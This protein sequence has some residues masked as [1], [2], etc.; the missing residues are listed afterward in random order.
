MKTKYY[1][2]GTFE[3]EKARLVVQGC[4]AIKGRDYDATRAPTCRM[5][6]VRLIMALMLIFG[7]KAHNS[8]I[9]QAV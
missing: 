2:D 9:K 8:D 3:K 1:P 6:S 5:D 4:L 7:W